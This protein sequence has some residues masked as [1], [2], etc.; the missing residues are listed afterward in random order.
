MITQDEIRTFE[1]AVFELVR[2]TI[3]VGE[4]IDT[5][6]YDALRETYA[7]KSH[8][9]SKRVVHLLLAGVVKAAA[10]QI[11]TGICIYPTAQRVKGIGMPV[12]GYCTISSIE[13]SIVSVAIVS[14]TVTV[15]PVYVV[16]IRRA[17]GATPGLRC[18]VSAK[19]RLPMWECKQPFSMYASTVCGDIMMLLKHLMCRSPSLAVHPMPRIHFS[20]PDDVTDLEKS[21]KFVAAGLSDLMTPGSWFMRPGVLFFIGMYAAILRLPTTDVVRLLRWI[22]DRIPVFPDVAWQPVLVSDLSDYCAEKGAVLSA[23]HLHRI[24]ETSSALDNQLLWAVPFEVAAKYGPLRSS[25]LMAGGIVFY[26]DA[27]MLIRMFRRET[28]DRLMAEW[29]KRFVAWW[30][31]LVKYDIEEAERLCSFC[32]PRSLFAAIPPTVLM[33]GEQRYTGTYLSLMNDEKTRLSVPLCLRS[34][35][36]A[37]PHKDKDRCILG[38]AAVDLFE[39][40]VVAIESIPDTRERIAKMKGWAQRAT[41]HVPLVCKSV[42][43]RYNGACDK[44]AGKLNPGSFNGPASATL[45]MLQKLEW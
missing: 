15:W 6:L 13:D 42:V 4:Y 17:N 40:P 2:S 18:L 24:E 7:Q 28:V 9:W 32:V 26:N 21:K 10:C 25:V 5:Q 12:S 44:C 38:H 29:E 34:A 19:H 33:D 20:V 31:R 43:T 37:I 39:D 45:Q 23:D 27:A 16:D 22:V 1:A 35:Y 41:V 30:H 3:R 8:A 36:N 14:G 11:D